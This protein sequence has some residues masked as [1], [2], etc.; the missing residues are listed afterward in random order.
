VAE[1]ERVRAVLRT[2]LL[3][4]DGLALSRVTHTHPV[5][6][7]LSVYQLVEFIARHEARHARQIAGI[8]EELH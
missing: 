7:V 1:V 5:L 2:T 6:G 3:E 4:A 8:A